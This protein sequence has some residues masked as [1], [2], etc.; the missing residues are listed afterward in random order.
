MRKAVYG[1]GTNVPGLAAVVT[2]RPN[3]YLQQL[4]SAYA[5]AHKD[6]L[7]SVIEKE[8]AGLVE[9]ALAGLV[10]L[11]MDMRAKLI[12]EA[13]G[14][15]GTDEALLV[16]CILASSQEELKEVQQ[17]WS[18]R[19]GI[20]VL[21]RV[22]ME[23]EPVGAVVALFDC[24]ATGELMGPFHYMLEQALS[25]NKPASG[26]LQDKVKMDLGMLFAAGEGKVGTDEMAIAKL[27]SS[28]S[29]EHLVFLNEEYKNASPKKRTLVEALKS[30]TAG[31]V[32]MA[33][34]AAVVTPAEWW[35]ERI[36]ESMK[37]AGTRE[38]DLVHHLLLP[39]QQQLKQIAAAFAKNREGDLISA[40]T[41]ELSGDLKTILVSYL[42]FQL[43]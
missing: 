25:P 22:M 19:Y 8:T 33:F 41:K 17:H 6:D 38:K 12:H 20:P 11:P 31:K 32:Q 21:A 36:F 13:C 10:R 5:S 35:E 42:K 40:V 27:L 7:V 37:G 23:G 43:A 1:A 16:S 9:E 4:R 29:R 14:G 28:R 30:E 18:K 39:N 15:A 24:F 3:A 34:V 26:I 2:Q